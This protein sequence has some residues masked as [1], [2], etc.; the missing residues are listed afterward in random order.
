MLTKNSACHFSAL[1]SVLVI[2]MAHATA[3]PFWVA[4]EG[5]DYPEDV[6]WTRQWG[7]ADGLYHGGA[8]RS[9]NNGLFTSYALH[10]PSVYDFQYQD[11]QIAI[12]P[13]EWFVATWRTLVD[14]ASDPLD[15]KV[16][17]TRSESAGH[18]S[19]SLGP[20]YVTVRPGPTQIAIEPNVFHTYTV[21]SYDMLSYVLEIDGV[22]IHSGDFELDSLLSSYVTF[23]D[24]VLGQR[25][26]A[27]WDYF[28]YGVVPEPVPLLGTCL[29]IGL[30]R[31]PR[32]GLRRRGSR[33]IE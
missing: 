23:G 29:V 6:G 20:E 10:D 32:W 24:G 31:S 33:S 13:D 9:L 12:A 5:N 18:V 28:R 2:G 21:T 17:L 4:Y 26:H 8:L 22:T 27:Q 14:P 30:L 3:D 11:V 16:V 19:F 7:D 15:T 25:S 1:L